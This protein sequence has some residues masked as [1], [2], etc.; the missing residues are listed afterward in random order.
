MRKKD[1]VREKRKGKERE[2]HVW[3]IWHF[4]RSKVKIHDQ[5]I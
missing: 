4:S 2:R 1:K 5:Y 3:T